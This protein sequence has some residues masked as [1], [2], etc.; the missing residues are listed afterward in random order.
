MIA[1]A[2]HSLAGD[3]HRAAAWAA[4]VRERNPA[5]TGEDFFRAFPIKPAPVRARVAGALARHGF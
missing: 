3:E 4:N 5:L 1:C 2:T